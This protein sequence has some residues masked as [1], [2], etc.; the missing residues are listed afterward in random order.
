MTELPILYK[1]T[2]NG[3]TQQWQIFTENG[4][5]FTRSGKVGG[6]IREST[7][8]ICELKNIGKANET[9]AEAQSEIEAK[10]KWDKQ[11]KKSY[12]TDIDDIDAAS[13]RFFEP[14]LAHPWKQIKYGD[15]GEI[16]YEVKDISFPC[17]SQR[18]YDGV[19]C[20][21]S[22][23]GAFSRKGERFAT[24]PH[25]EALFAPIFLRYPNAVFDGELY[26]HEYKED[27]E[28]ITSLVKKK[29]PTVAEIFESADK[30]QY[31]IYDNPQLEGAQDLER[32]FSVRYDNMCTLFKEY[33]E[34][35][36]ASAIQVVPTFTIE[37]EADITTMHDKFVDDEGYEGIMLRI[38]GPYMKK[39]TNLLLKHKIFITEEYPV[40]KFIAGKGNKAHCAA[41]VDC[42]LPDGRVFSA[43]IVGSEDRAVELLMSSDELKGDLATI[44]YFRMTKAG[45]PRFGKFL[46]MRDYE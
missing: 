41:K 40:I 23:A 37:Q 25:I 26:N 43:G 12:T 11:L 19:R 42:R 29:R 44:R 4:G 35:V 21:L 9:T 34:I 22:K 3:A 31:H 38:D 32:F 8:T 18:K 13:E 16:S 39:R 20:I 1:R 28:K 24:T 27:F 17:Y 14:M 45:I 10:A 2:S 30:L 36:D 33:K 7:P 5:F 46:A 6:K 15:N